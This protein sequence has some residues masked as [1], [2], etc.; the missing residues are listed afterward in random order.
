MRGMLLEFRSLDIET[1]PWA[2]SETQVPGA[3]GNY[4]R[5]LKNFQNNSN[6]ER[7]KEEL[8]V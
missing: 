5:N 2:L 6:C 3:F 1:L 7:V 4:I 8:L